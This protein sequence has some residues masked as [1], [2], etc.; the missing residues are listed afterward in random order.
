MNIYVVI[1]YMHIRITR[2]YQIIILETIEY[3]EF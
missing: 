3:F 1:E 2:E